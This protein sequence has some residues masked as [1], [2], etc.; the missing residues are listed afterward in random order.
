MFNYLK[1]NFFIFIMSEWKTTTI[2]NLKTYKIENHLYYGYNTK[3]YG[4]KV[5]VYKCSKQ[6]KDTKCP[7]ELRIVHDDNDIYEYRNIHN[8]ESELDLKEKLNIALN[9]LLT[10]NI[11]FGK[12]NNIIMNELKNNYQIVFEEEDKHDLK[13]KINLFKTNHN[14]K[15]HFIKLIT[16]ADLD[17]WA[18]LF[19]INVDDNKAYI[20]NKHISKEDLCICISSNELIK[21]IIWFMKTNPYYLMI[22]STYKINSN[23]YPIVTIG[24]LTEQRKY[25]LLAIYLVNK[26]NTN[27]YT[28]IFNMLVKVFNDLSA[29][30]LKPNYLISDDA[31]YILAASR[32]VFKGINNILCQFHIKKNIKKNVS[33]NVSN[34]EHKKLIT[35]NLYFSLQLTNKGL[36]NKYLELVNNMA[37]KI[38]L[39]NYL[40]N[41]FFKREKSYNIF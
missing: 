41:E 24:L 17:T 34:K 20:I 13:K 10:K 32:I 1:N 15:K 12:N 11:L 9:D 16:F 39:K 21:N 19:S 5:S 26:E 22:D 31:E 8:H 4:L 23:K 27:I 35:N 29:F 36:F 33:K 37:D 25:L 7:F 14:N 6:N 2:K 30:D 28:L 40:N 38:L 3:V 18:N